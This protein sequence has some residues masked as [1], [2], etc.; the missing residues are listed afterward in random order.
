MHGVGVATGAGGR[1][2]RAAAV[3]PSLGTQLQV[4]LTAAEGASARACLLPGTHTLA[5]AR[6]DARRRAARVPGTCAT[7]VVQANRL[8]TLRL[9]GRAAPTRSRSGSPRRRTRRATT[10]VRL[11]AERVVQALPPG[12]RT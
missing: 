10:T 12:L 8:T 2:A 5:A 7:G 9:A 11:F 3:T 6:R 1:S 4:Q